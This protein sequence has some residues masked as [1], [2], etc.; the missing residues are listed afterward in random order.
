MRSWKKL[1][2]VLTLAMVLSMTIALPVFAKVPKQPT[3]IPIPQYTT[4]PEVQYIPEPLQDKLP[5]DGKVYTEWNSNVHYNIVREGIAKVKRDIY[6]SGSRLTK[7]VPGTPFTVEQALLN[8]VNWPDT[9]ETDVTTGWLFSG[10]FYDAD[11]GCNYAGYTNP[12]AYTR[13]NNHYY[14]AINA[15]TAQ[16]AYNELAYSLHYLGDL[17]APHHA[18]NVPYAL[19]GDY[20][21]SSFE[22]YADSNYSNYQTSWTG[23]YWVANGNM[24][25]IANYY[26]RHAKYYIEDAKSF[27]NNRYARAIEST[28]PYAQSAAAGMIYRFLLQTSW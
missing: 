4:T 9:W 1:T 25:D 22:S 13:F 14:N 24:L 5:Y 3:E 16:V 10:H 12:T 26:S 6:W 2:S 18:A 28:L 7:L 8:G 19:T 23:D 21:H 15:S 27:E 11:S 17:N 20:S